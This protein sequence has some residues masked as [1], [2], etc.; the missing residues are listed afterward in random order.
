[1]TS[2]RK[3]V[4]QHYGCPRIVGSNYV[5]SM[6]GDLVIRRHP[7]CFIAERIIGSGEVCDEIAVRVPDSV[8]YCKAIALDLYRWLEEDLIDIMVVGDYFWLQPWE[9]SVELGHK[10]EVPVYPSLSGS[11]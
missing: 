5:I 1:M 9:R 11:R 7:R 10:Y 4:G 2:A 6:D 8:G 3:D